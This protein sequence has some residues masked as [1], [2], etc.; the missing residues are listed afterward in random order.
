MLFSV[1]ASSEFM[2]MQHEGE[3]NDGDSHVRI[4]AEHG[5]LDLLGKEV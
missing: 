5:E 4:W 1:S 3:D 2:L